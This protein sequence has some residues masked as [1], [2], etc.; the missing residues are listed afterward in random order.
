MK[1]NILFIAFLVLARLDAFSQEPVI[2]NVV[3]ELKYIRD[4]SQ[5]NNP[6]IAN[7]ILSLGKE[8]CHYK[9]KYEDNSTRTF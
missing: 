9:R 4:L 5:K 2:F 8:G 7:M 6:L 3:Y 1:R